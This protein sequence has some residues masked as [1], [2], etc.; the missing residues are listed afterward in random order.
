MYVKVVRGGPTVGSVT[1]ELEVQMRESYPELFRSGN[2][3]ER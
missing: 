3:L 2:F 1:W